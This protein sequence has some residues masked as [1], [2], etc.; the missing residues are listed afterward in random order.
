[1]HKNAKI[2]I[3]LFSLVVLV[4]AGCEGQTTDTSTIKG[5]YKATGNQLIAAKFATDYPISMEADPY[6]KGEPIDVVVELSNMHSEDIE[7][8]RVEVRLA[9]D[10]AITT[11]FEGARQ[12]AAPLLPKYDE[13]ASVPSPEEVDLGPLNYVGE[14]PT[15]VAKQITGQYCYEYPVKVKAFLYYTDSPTDIGTNLPSGSNPPSSLQVTAVQQQ[16]VDVRDGVG[17]LKFRVTVKNVGS[18]TLIPSMNECFQYRGKREREFFTLEALGA[19]PIVCENDGYV[20]LSRDTKEKIVDC[21]VTGIDASNLGTQAS[22]LSLTLTGFAY[23]DNIA[24][25]T[26]WLEP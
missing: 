7:A 6:Q 16:A 9:G 15:K 24:P 19:Y 17:K 21:E 14:L 8:G 25:V 13:I 18:G 1:M 11:F 26:I 4:I 22:E 5:P 3:V 12:V 10:A 2:S 20:R 23:E